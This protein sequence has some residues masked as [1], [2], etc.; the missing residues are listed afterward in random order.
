M[1]QK[2]AH[3][4]TIIYKQ[5]PHDNQQPA[6]SAAC[7]SCNACY[8]YRDPLPLKKIKDSTCAQTLAFLGLSAATSPLTVSQFDRYLWTPVDEGIDAVLW[9]ADNNNLYNCNTVLLYPF[10]YARELAE[11]DG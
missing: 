9:W 5:C 10:N 3:N 7:T 8:C 11:V 1:Q 2:T 4:K 6:E